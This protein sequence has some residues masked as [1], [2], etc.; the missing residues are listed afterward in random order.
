LTVDTPEGKRSGSSVVE[1]KVYFT[2]GL[3]RAQGYGVLSRVQGEATVIDLGARG[4]LFVTLAD[5]G[6]RSFPCGA[7]SLC[8]RHLTGH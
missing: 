6:I 7:P 5:E 1:D 4:M 8:Y 3:T 2:G